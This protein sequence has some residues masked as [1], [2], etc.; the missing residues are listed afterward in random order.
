[1]KL[2]VPWCSLCDAV[3]QIYHARG[4]QFVSR[5]NVDTRRCYVCAPLLRVTRMIGRYLC[6][7]RI[8]RTYTITSKKVHM[9]FYFNFLR[10]CTVN[11]YYIYQKVA[12]Y[13]CVLLLSFLLFTLLIVCISF[14]ILNYCYRYSLFC[15]SLFSF[16]IAIV[17]Y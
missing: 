14:D 5:W 13:S 9:S 1:V 6:A 4:W 8:T 15:S 11:T 2:A 10:C 12:K 17:R 7:E 3:I 16:F